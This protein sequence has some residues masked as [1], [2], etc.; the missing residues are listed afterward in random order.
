MIFDPM[1]LLF[2]FPGLGLSMWASARVKSSLQ[3]G[4]AA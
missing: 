3:G 2:I 1:Y 4:M